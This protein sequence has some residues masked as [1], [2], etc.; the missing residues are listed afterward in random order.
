MSGI[1]YFIVANPILAYTIVFLGMFIEGEGLIIFASIFA[2]QGIL[3]WWLLALAVITGTIAGDIIWYLGGR[4]LRNTRLGNWLDRRYEAHTDTLDKNIREHYGRLAVLS[5]FMYFTTHPTIFLVGWNRFPLKKFLWITCYATT[6]WAITVLAVGYSFGYAIELIGFK[7]FVHRIELFA[8]IIFASIFILGKV[9]KTLLVKANTR[10]IRAEEFYGASLLQQL[11]TD[12]QI[13]DHPR[14][15]LFTDID[16]TFFRAEKREASQ[17]LSDLLAEHKTPLVAV[18][19]ASFSSILARIEKGELPYFAA[20]AGAVGTELW[21]LTR[22]QAGV[23]TYVRDDFYDAQLRK[24]CFNRTALVI[25]SVQFI[26][27]MKDRF[28]EANFAFQDPAAEAAYMADD[29]SPHQPYKISFHFFASLN[30]LE[31]VRSF[32]NDLFPKQRLIFCEEI[33]HNKTLPADA[34]I[35]KYCMDIL[36]TTK[37]NVITY[38]ASMLELR[39][40]L[41][42]GDSGNDIEMLTE[43][44]APVVLSALVG[45]HTREAANRLAS[46]CKN[47]TRDES[48]FI[49]LPHNERSRRI[50]LI[51]DN[52]S[53]LAAES[54]LHILEHYPLKTTWAP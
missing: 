54:I 23:L 45:G 21:I 47:G 29:S 3:N 11:I 51:D 30:S 6:I 22:N 26:K 10:R 19:G 48:G 5:K 12:Q 18:S 17:K 15:A 25:R 31:K 13:A 14:T 40:M 49:H 16:N 36:P 41:V 28:P 9:I 2:W 44:E 43:P 38:L 34:V 52:S 1:E 7:Q 24:R 4:Y 27:E 32:A 53:R 35:K 39:Q 50:I 46:F 33:N 8:V 20:V 42:A 37:A